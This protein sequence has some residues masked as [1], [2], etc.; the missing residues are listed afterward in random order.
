VAADPGAVV[1]APAS[2]RTAS[3]AVVVHGGIQNANWKHGPPRGLVMARSPPAPGHDEGGPFNWGSPSSQPRGAGAQG[4]RLARAIVAAADRLPDGQPVELHVIAH[5]EGAVV[6][7]Q[8]LQ[9]LGPA[10]IAGIA[11]GHVKLTLLD[12][13]AANNA[14]PGRQYSVA[15]GLL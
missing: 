8:A 14:G 10:P 15:G 6:A 4:K 1:A 12:P 7:T 2:F 9:R 3:L 5:S 13:H 11:A